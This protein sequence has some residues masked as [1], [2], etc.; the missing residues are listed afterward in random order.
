MDLLERIEGVTIENYGPGGD[1]DTDS[2]EVTRDQANITVFGMNVGA[3]EVITT[4]DD[5]EVNTIFACQ[6]AK[7]GMVNATAADHALLADLMKVLAGWG[8]TPDTAG[9]KAH[10]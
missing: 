5:R 4:P 7:E 2:L 8:I 10:F 1:F 9:W 6:S 3:A